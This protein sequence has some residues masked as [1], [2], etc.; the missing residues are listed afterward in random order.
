MCYFPLFSSILHEKLSLPLGGQEEES[1]IH[2]S[3]NEKKRIAMPNSN[4]SAYRWRESIKV[5][6]RSIH[7]F[8]SSS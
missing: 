8:D 1:D 3:R 6:L 7:C 5:Q 2:G 4:K